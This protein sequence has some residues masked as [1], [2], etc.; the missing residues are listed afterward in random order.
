[1]KNVFNF[2]THASTLTAG[3]KNG[4]VS[5]MNEQREKGSESEQHNGKAAKQK[6]FLFIL[7]KYLFIFIH[8]SCMVHKDR[9]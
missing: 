8:F 4:Q 9:L 7:I 3:Y 5:W 2:H 1:M 6:S